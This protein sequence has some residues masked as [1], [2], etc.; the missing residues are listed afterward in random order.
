M[1]YLVTGNLE[2]FEN[3]SYKV[4]G[5]DESLSLLSSLEV[6]S[7]DTETGGLDEYTKDLKSVQLGNKNF[8]IVIDTSTIDIKKYKELFESDKLFLFWNAL[9]DLRFLYINNIYPNSVLFNR[10]KLTGSSENDLILSEV[11]PVGFNNPVFLEGNILIN[12]NANKFTF[13]N[14]GKK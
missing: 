8:Q 6:I 5:V 4:I 2:L 7:V 14:M 9:F 13:Y 3:K 11:Y 1:I 10:V 12:Q